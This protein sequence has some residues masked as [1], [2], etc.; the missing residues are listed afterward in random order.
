M[1]AAAIQHPRSGES[2]APVLAPNWDRGRG[3]FPSQAA[4]VRG[5]FSIPGA[6]GFARFLPVTLP[7]RSH[8]RRAGLFERV[9]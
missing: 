5:P 3:L 1:P 9:D 6:R 4:P 7:A 8:P 2:A